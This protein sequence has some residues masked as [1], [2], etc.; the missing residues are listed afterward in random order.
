MPEYPGPFFYR[1]LETS[2]A[3]PGRATGRRVCPRPLH[4]HLRRR[5]GLHRLG[6]ALHYELAG[7][8]VDVLNPAPGP[9]R[10]EGRRERQGIDG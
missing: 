2:A 4:G 1:S 10:T 8:G 7:S 3:V 9:V 6:Q 5:Q